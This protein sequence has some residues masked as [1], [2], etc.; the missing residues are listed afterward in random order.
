MSEFPEVKC[1]HINAPHHQH[2]LV[3][4]EGKQPYCAWCREL[5][6]C[7]AAGRALQ[8]CG[9]PRA[10]IV[11][12]KEGTSYCAWCESLAVERNGFIDLIKDRED[13]A[14]DNMEGCDAE[15]LIRWGSTYAAMRELR[16][17]LERVLLPPEV[18]P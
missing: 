16:E 12:S 6:E 4:P 11:D 10:V 9:H 2:V 1:R 3:C 8:P 17:V 13:T 5:E 18:K 15:E 7:V 14:H